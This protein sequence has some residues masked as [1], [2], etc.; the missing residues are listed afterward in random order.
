MGDEKRAGKKMG[1]VDLMQRGVK[2]SQSSHG[3]N[4]FSNGQNYDQ[5]FINIVQMHPSGALEQ[6]LIRKQMASQLRDELSSGNDP[7]LHVKRMHTSFQ[8]HQAKRMTSNDSF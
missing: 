7:D 2:K 5:K 6:V 4:R 8:H 1:K 3:V